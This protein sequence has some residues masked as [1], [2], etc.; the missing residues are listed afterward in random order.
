MEPK[1]ANTVTQLHCHEPSSAGCSKLRVREGG[2][3]A[4]SGS[5]AE[6]AFFFNQFNLRCCMI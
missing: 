2:I 3:D 4:K 1:M 6:S 5:A